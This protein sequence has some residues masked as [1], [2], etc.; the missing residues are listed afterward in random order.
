MNMSSTRKLA[1]I[2]FADIAGY[3]AIMQEDEYMALQK[4]NHFRNDI[5]NIVPQFSGEIIQYYGDGCLLIF[6]SSVEAINCSVQLQISLKTTPSVPVRIGVHQGDIV[7]EKD[8]VFGNNV[9]IAARIESMSIPGAILL[10]GKVQSELSNQAGIFLQSLGSYEFKNVAEPIEVFAYAHEGFPVP[11][12]NEITGKFKIQNEEKSIAVLPFKNQSSDA[13]QEYFSDGIAEDIIYG[14]SQLANLKVAGLRSSFSFKNSAAALSEIATQLKV[15][16]LLEGSVRKANKKIRVNVQL[17]SAKDGFQIWTERFDGELED[18]F[19]IQDEIAEKV[20]SK[21]KLTLLGQ[22]KAHSPINRKT[23]NVQAYELYL[24]GRSYLDKRVKTEDALN[25]FNKAIEIDSNF[26]AAYTGVAYA[27]FYEMVFES[28]PP[29]EGWPKAATAIQKALSLDNSIAEAHT[30]QG[31]VEIYH[32]RCLEKAR[33]EFER[34]IM[35]QPKLADT[36]RVKAYFH[37]IAGEKDKAV[38]CA[39]KS[40]SLDPLSFNNSYSLGDIYYR[41]R[42]YHSAAKTFEDLA[43]KYPHNMYVLGMLAVFYYFQGNI[44]KTRSLF[45]QCQG[46]QMPSKF[47]H[48]STERFVV[49]ARL[50]RLDIARE[51]LQHLLDVSTK[52]WVS[53]M[54]ISMMFFSLGEEK[55]G[56]KSLQKALED[57]DILAHLVH[58]LPLWDEHRDLPEVQNLL[59]SWREVDNHSSDY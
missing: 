16:N 5:E 32:H 29:K 37:I 52:R 6:N 33:Q 34:A 13:E 35:L 3:T 55:K 24:M 39:E 7:V 15:D 31:Q 19:S 53:P 38:E 44:A 47:D 8:N 48:Y 11:K 28:H 45:D 18:I 56:L 46:Y 22:E 27:Y 36:Y 4:L 41:S 23:K 49:I 40:Y 54:F 17:V 25:C 9:N 26:A 59:H 50:G 14:L 51:Y 43:E 20:V 42:L 30:M 10:S 57:N 58:S 1:A 21:M 2:V 12:A